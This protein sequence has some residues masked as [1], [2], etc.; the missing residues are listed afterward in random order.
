[1][2][3]SQP[4]LFN[5]A[6]QFEHHGAQRWT[7]VRSGDFIAAKTLCSAGDSARS[8]ATASNRIDR[9]K[10]H[11]APKIEGKRRTLNAQRPTFI[12]SFRAGSRNPVMK[13]SGNFT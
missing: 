10:I 12:L 1:M 9:R 4:P 6:W 8:D 13:S 7:T 5:S 11:I 3:F 2:I